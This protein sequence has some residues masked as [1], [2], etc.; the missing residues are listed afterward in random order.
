MHI[1]TLV[2]FLSEQVAY[3][4]FAFSAGNFI[5]MN[6]WSPAFRNKDCHLDFIVIDY[7]III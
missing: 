3:L 1:W 7:C 4:L 6:Q 5:E 2:V